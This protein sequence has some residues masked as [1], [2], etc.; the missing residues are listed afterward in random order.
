MNEHLDPTLDNLPP[1]DKEFDKA[2]KDT[3]SKK[4]KFDDG[5]K[6]MKVLRSFSLEILYKLGRVEEIYERIEKTTS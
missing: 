2:L 3:D 4:E 1:E 6:A 5:S